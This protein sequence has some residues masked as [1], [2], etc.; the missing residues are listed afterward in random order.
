[1]CGCDGS[2]AGE[3]QETEERSQDGGLRAH[4]WL[5]MALLLLSTAAI[6]KPSGTRTAC[7]VPVPG[8]DAC[9]PGGISWNAGS[10]RGAG[11]PREMLFLVLCP[12]AA[13]SHGAHPGGRQC[14]WGPSS[15]LA[16][17]TQLPSSCSMAVLPFSFNFR[18]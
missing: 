2:K 14:L 8:G 9:R 12:E 18:Q 3:W 1:M 11:G 7:H 17:L 5:L 16:G 10:A 15:P 13:D 6:E 4:R